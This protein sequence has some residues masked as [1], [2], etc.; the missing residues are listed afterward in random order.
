MTI[1]S[2]PTPRLETVRRL[3]LRIPAIESGGGETGPGQGQ[4]NQDPEEMIIQRIV[5]GFDLFL[6]FTITAR[7]S[8]SRSDG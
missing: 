2:P 3:L 6:F 5:Y 7:E 8:P 4:R 1:S